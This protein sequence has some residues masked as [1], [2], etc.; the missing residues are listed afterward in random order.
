M[1]LRMEAFPMGLRLQIHLLFHNN[2]Q[3]TCYH[4]MFKALKLRLCVVSLLLLLS[5]RSLT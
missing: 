5:R 4:S 2:Q 3:L 1:G